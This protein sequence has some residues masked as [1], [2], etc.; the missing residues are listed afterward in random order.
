MTKIRSLA[1][2]LESE[3]E[4]VVWRID[5]LVPTEGITL[6]TGEPGAGKTWIAADMAIRIANGLPVCGH[7][8]KQTGVLYIAAE[9]G[10]RRMMRR[11]RR[12]AMPI[13]GE[14]TAP[15]NLHLYPG[16]IRLDTTDGVEELR[17]M[18]R[19]LGVGVCVLDPFVR[20]IGEAEENSNTEIA[21]VFAALDRITRD[22][23]CDF[24]LV[25]HTGKGSHNGTYAARGASVISSEVASHINLTRTKA[26]EISI[27]QPKNRDDEP[28]QTIKIRLKDVADGIR[29]VPEQKSAK[30]K[31]A[32]RSMAEHI[33][34]CG[35]TATIP[36]IASQLGIT[37]DAARK[38]LE[39]SYND[40][41][42]NKQERGIYTI[43]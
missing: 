37:L 10:S 25:H 24:L 11:L 42:I 1:H 38:R 19:E 13:I 26:G 17:K 27:T 22:T 33:E 15:D 43:N 7:Q 3:Q 34:D 41:K 6:I 9:G 4:E 31:P 29:I 23:G 16:V 39:R 20:L 36:V 8:S 40:G 35:G 21:Q 30:P 2:I 32:V 14:I 18:I 28:I 12:L 5:K